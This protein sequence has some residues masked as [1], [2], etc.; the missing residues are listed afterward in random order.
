MFR[1][2]SIGDET[3]PAATRDSV[4]LELMLTK[5]N[6]VLMLMFE[7][8][9]SLTFLDS[10]EFLENL[11]VFVNS[12]VLAGIDVKDVAELLLFKDPLG[13]LQSNR[14]D[15]EAPIEALLDFVAGTVTFDDLLLQVLCWN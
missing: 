7:S 1:L 14:L 10:D 3:E 4:S 5:L 9:A 11:L 8:D 2:V 12:A 6:R 13:T 15:K